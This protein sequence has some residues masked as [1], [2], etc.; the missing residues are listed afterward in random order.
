[1]RV[2]CQVAGGSCRPE[3]PPEEEQMALAWLDH[4]RLGMP[5]PAFDHLQCVIDRE[6]PGK[7]AATCAQAQEA[8]QGGPRESNAAS[9]VET[10]AQSPQGRRMLIAGAVDSVEKQI[11]VLKHHRLRRYR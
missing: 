11:G 6:G 3:Q 5:E 4:L 8:Q 7:D 10:L 9:L 2:G 1:M